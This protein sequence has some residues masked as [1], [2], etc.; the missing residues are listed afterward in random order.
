MNNQNLNIIVENLSKK[1]SYYTT[2]RLIF[3]K[4]NIVEAVRDISFNVKKG[5][6]LGIIGP[7]GSGKTT[8]VKMVSGIIARDKG[9][10]SINGED[11]FKRSYRYRNSV[12]IFLGQK[13]RLNPDTSL[14]EYAKVHGSMYGLSDKEISNRINHITNML[15]L[16]EEKT[17]KPVRNLSLGER[18]KCEITLTFLNY[19]IVC[20]LDEP[21]LGLDVQSQRA[22][23]RFL[24]DYVREHNSSIILTSHDMQDIEEVSERI[25]IIKKGLEVYFGPTKNVADK[26]EDSLSISFETEKGEYQ[27]L[28]DKSSYL[29][30]FKYQIDNNKVIILTR[31]EEKDEIINLLYKNLNVKNLTIRSISFEDMVERLINHE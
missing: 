19:P 1:Y 7:N 23:R 20:F 28:L 15:S 26:F 10:I 16:S 6:V 9:N 13:T 29:Q 5:E 8:I 14:V 22:I 31:E 21:T 17:L 25:L 30:S 24:K 4:K 2:K 18:M 27:N 12:G 3:K 11:P